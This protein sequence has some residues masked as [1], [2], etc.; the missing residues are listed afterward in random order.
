MPGG[1]SK[2]K[3]GIT[4][5]RISSWKTL[6]LIYG[7]RISET[8]ADGNVNEKILV[9]LSGCNFRHRFGDY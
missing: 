2:R 9:L 1:K 7:L 4:S 5:V 8:D 6:N 3:N